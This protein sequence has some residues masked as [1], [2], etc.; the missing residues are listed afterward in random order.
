MDAYGGDPEAGRRWLERYADLLNTEHLDGFVPFTR[1][2]LLAGSD[3]ERA[4]AWYDRSIAASDRVNLIYTGHIA[5]V[6]RAAALIRL[7]RRDDAVAA[8]RSALEAVRSANMTAQVW[9]MIRLIAELLDGLG[10]RETASALVA[11]A[12]A[13]PMAP[14]V[15]GPDRERLAALRDAVSAPAP[16]GGMAAAV[17]LAL[18]RLAEA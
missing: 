17:E 8:C 5:R 14:A 15:M 6:A 16:V 1:G 3:P 2:E 12:D 13:D 7:E 9:T 10:D 11:A 4:L 18:R